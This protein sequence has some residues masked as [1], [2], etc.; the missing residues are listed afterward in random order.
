MAAVEGS[1]LAEQMDVE[2]QRK[3]NVRWVNTCILFV[4]GITDQ[5]LPMNAVWATIF[6][7]IIVNNGTEILPDICYKTRF[8]SIEIVCVRFICS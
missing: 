3:S 8:P 1:Q 4:T 5:V 6:M 7:D 2:D